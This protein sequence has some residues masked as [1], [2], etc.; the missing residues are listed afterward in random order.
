MKKLLQIGMVYG[1]RLVIPMM[2]LLI[3]WYGFQWL[4][5]PIEKEPAKPVAAKKIKSR[6]A[7]LQPTD[8]TVQVE[9]N[10]YVGMHDQVT[11]SAEVLGRITFVDPRFEVGSYVPADAVLVQLD[12]RDYQTALRVAQE[13]N[14]R[15]KAAF[16]LAQKAFERF[17]QLVR[18]NN[19]SQAELDTAE[20]ALAT[21]RAEVEITDAA[22][23][24]SQRDLERTKIRA[25]FEGR[26][27]SR[28]VGQGQ[29]LAPGTVLG[30]IF[31]VDY[32]EVRLPIA[33]RNL[34]FLDLPEF[35]GDPEVKIELKDGL[36]P[37]SN[38]TW[39]GSIIR[40]EGILDASSLEL[41]AIA[42]IPDP[43]AMHRDG[44]PLR[45]GQPVVAT[46][47]GETLEDVIAIP[48]DAVRRLREV[49]LIDP[50]TKRLRTLS[51][52]PLWSDEE[53]VIVRD[54]Q[55]QPG[56]YVATTMLVYAPQ[57]AEVDIIP[58]IDTSTLAGDP[59]PGGGEL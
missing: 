52:N 36:N 6:V 55:I 37:N 2:I 18:Q 22:V 25:P 27:A 3:G 54:S 16:E 32:A 10:G 24:R 33:M 28:E 42:R 11:L 41:F 58:A 23:N 51:I 12:D 29:L 56:D 19:I 48:R 44:S 4:S 46:I 7:E 38:E 8:Y 20:G 34:Q 14:R 17:E 45:I 31:A 49:H 30:Q 43:F 15:A 35:D 26:V 53:L 57:D 39:E 13:E 9:A 40:T 21:A 50:D 59:P 5:I 1:L 47:Y